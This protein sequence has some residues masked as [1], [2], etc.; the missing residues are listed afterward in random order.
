M[1]GIETLL[2]GFRKFRE[3]YFEKDPDLYRDLLRHG[4]KPR[5]AVVACSDSRVD[6]AAR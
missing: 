4:Q 3:M 6:P 1:T 2:N 5:F